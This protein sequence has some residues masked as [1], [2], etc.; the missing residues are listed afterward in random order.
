MKLYVGLDL[1]LQ[2]TAV[3]VVDEKGETVFKRTIV[4]EAEALLNC[5][6]KHQE[7]IELVGLEACPL[8]EWLHAALIDI[9]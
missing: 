7:D 6:S 4:S 1:G 5:L 9:G 2:K 8:S 3:C